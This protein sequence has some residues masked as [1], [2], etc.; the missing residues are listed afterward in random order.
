VL[1]EP[2]SVRDGQAVLALPGGLR[3]VA[4][5][6]PDS[7]DP[8]HQFADT[9]GPPLSSVLRWRHSHRFASAGEH[10]TVVIDE[11][12]TPVPARMLRRCSATGTG[13]SRPISPRTRAR[14]LCPEPLTI[15]GHRLRRAHRIG[16]GGAADHRRSP[17]HPHGPPCAAARR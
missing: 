10:R 16:P 12:D 1:R 6:D 11:V 7:Y 4:E 13:S 15:A 8:P 17:G 9:L 14:E 2:P 3:W 5:H